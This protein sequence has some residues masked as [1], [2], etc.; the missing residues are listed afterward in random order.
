MFENILELL[1]WGRSLKKSCIVFF[2]VVSLF[3]LRLFFIECIW[4]SILVNVFEDIFFVVLSVLKSWINF[5]YLFG[6]VIKYGFIL[7]F[8]FN[9]SVNCLYGN[10]FGN[11][12]IKIKGNFF[13]VEIF[14]DD[15]IFILFVYL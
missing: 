12:D 4:Y 8:L 5:K 9:W 7:Y 14:I 13:K 2:I 15:N 3:V 10:M 11:F 1:F 6:I